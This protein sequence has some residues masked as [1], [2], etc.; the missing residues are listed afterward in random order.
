VKELARQPGARENRWMHRLSGEP[1]DE[2]AAA[3][4]HEAAPE[5]ISAS[6]IATLRAE[7][8]ELRHQVAALNETVAR[9]GQGAR[10]P[11]MKKNPVV[12]LPGLLEDADGFAHQIAGLAEVAEIVVATSPDPIPMQAL[13]SDALSQAPRGPLRARPGTRWGATSLSKSCARRRDAFSALAL[14]NTNARADTPE[15]TENRRRLMALRKKDFE[16]GHRG[17]HAAPGHAR[18]PRRSRPSPPRSARWPSPWGPDAFVPP[19]DGHHRARRQP[20]RSCRRSPVRRSSSPAATTSS[21]RS[22]SSRKWPG[23][24][25]GAKLVVVEDCAHAAMLEQ[26]EAVTDALYL[27]LAG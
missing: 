16:A 8:S 26:P 14:L 27:W 15:G 24:I 17:A 10:P 12:L 20:I 6:E 2:P 23:A 19:A 4:P 5:A 13:A 25:P 18:A 22:R 9:P 1:A 21:C 7:I 11:A 3:M